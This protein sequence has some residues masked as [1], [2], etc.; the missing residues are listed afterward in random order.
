[1]VTSSGIF[2]DLNR[3]SKKFPGLDSFVYKLKDFPSFSK[4]TDNSIK[5]VTTVL[6]SKVS[7]QSSL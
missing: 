3:F 5:L 4:K 6:F 2:K 7:L 1:M